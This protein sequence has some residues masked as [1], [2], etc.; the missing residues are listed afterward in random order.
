MGGG[1]RSAPQSRQEMAETRQKPDP[2]RSKKRL[3]LL[4]P[5]P[6][7]PASIDALSM[8][9]DGRYMELDGV[10]DQLEVVGCKGVRGHHLVAFK[11]V[12]VND[13][14]GLCVFSETK[15]QLGQDV[16]C[17]SLLT[18]L[19]N[20]KLHTHL[21]LTY[22]Y[23]QVKHENTARS[24]L[25]KTTSDGNII[26]HS[27]IERDGKD[28][29][30]HVHTHSEDSLQKQEMGCGFDDLLEGWTILKLVQSSDSSTYWRLILSSSGH[31]L[32][33]ERLYSAGLYLRP[34]KSVPFADLSS[35]H[36]M[37]AEE[38]EM[39][40]TERRQRIRRRLSASLTTCL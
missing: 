16:E 23:S 40:Y 6:P 39:F 20:S 2:D 10:H 19:I 7:P 8:C 22:D 25:V 9:I 30:A 35:I 13:S 11:Q 17:G 3:N 29:E 15:I 31:L 37:N 28:A 4:T 14:Y 36:W 1:Y 27:N 38:M 33:H 26:V 12:P 32:R 5:P 34:A 24:V 18:S 21:E